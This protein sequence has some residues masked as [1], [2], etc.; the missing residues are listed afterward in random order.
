[1]YGRHK[2]NFYGLCGGI[3]VLLIVTLIPRF[4]A[5][6]EYIVIDNEQTTAHY[7]ITYHSF[8]LTGKEYSGHT[9]QLYKQVAPFTFKPMGEYTDKTNQAGGISSI[10]TNKDYHINGDDLLLGDFKIFL[11]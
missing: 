3:F 5:A 4:T 1:M 2:T 9:V 8:T 6:K 10:L 11:H 7:A